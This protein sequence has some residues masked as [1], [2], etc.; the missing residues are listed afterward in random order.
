MA[1]VVSYTEAMLDMGI[2]TVTVAGMEVMVMATVVMSVEAQS[3]K[4]SSEHLQLSAAEIVTLCWILV[5][6]HSPASEMS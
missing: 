3:R 1:S 2:Y 5:A 4:T 6:M